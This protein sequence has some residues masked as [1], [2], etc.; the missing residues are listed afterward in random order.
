MDKTMTEQHFTQ[1]Y[2]TNIDG[3]TERK[4][5]L[6]YLSWAYAWKL[7]KTSDPKAT[8]KTIKYKEADGTEHI[9]HP[10]MHGG[11]FVEVSVTCHGIT[12]T[13]EH[14]IIDNRNRS[15]LKP[16]SRQVS[17]SKHRALAKCCAYHGVGLVLWTGETIEIEPEPAADWDQAEFEKALPEGWDMGK[18][19][20][21]CIERKWP[22]PHMVDGPR[23]EKLIQFLAEL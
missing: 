17:D 4:G 9:M 7:I 8:F 5:N 19:H 21:L 12:L 22:L 13:C 15:I 16:D 1:L 14:P 2:N 10:H 23:R 6:D 11:G 3:L 18:V 20:T